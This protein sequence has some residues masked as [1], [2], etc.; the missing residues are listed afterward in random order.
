MGASRSAGNWFNR[1]Y[2]NL[3]LKLLNASH[4]H[5]GYFLNLHGYKT[6]YE[7]TSDDDFDFLQAF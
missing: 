1:S 2:E 6:V 7:A 5:S 3:K 4:T